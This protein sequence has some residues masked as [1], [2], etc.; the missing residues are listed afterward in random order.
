ML[1]EGGQF[2]KQEHKGD[3]KEQRAPLPLKDNE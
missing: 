1:P 2:R 3:R